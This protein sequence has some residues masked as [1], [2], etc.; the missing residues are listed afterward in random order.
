MCVGQATSSTAQS[1]GAAAK[2]LAD[3]AWQVASS[4]V[5]SSRRDVTADS[6]PMSVSALSARAQ[7]FHR[8]VKKFIEEH[9]LPVEQ[10]VMTWH[11]TPRTKWMTHPR[12]E[13]LKVR[14]Y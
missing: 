9:I 6:L 2:L 3:I 5:T 4:S 1:A 8:R 10:D 11:L 12:I 7:D 13:Q 14:R